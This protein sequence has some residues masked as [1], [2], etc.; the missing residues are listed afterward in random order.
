MKAPSRFLNKSKGE[1]L[2]KKTAGVDRFESELWDHVEQLCFEYFT[3]LA[4]LAGEKVRDDGRTV[5]EVTDVQS[6]EGT[7]TR[8]LTPESLMVDLHALAAENV[9]G[10][11]K[12]NKLITDWVKAEQAKG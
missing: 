11:A 10:I 12:L 1:E 5:I 7:G 4:R 6:P 3:E 8:K 2:F 9:S